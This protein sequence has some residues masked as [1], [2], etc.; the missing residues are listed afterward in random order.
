[1]NLLSGES[2]N[3]FFGGE[4]PPAV[5]RL[6]DQ[7]HGAPARET[8]ALLWTAQATAPDCLAVYYLLYKFH[9]GR[10]EFELAERAACSG[11]AVAARQAGLAED[12]RDVPA[13]S[14]DFSRPGPA[15]FW[16]FTLK[17]L[18][19]IKLRQGEVALAN[20][21]IGKIEALHPNGGLGD[22]VVAAL[23]AGLGPR[24]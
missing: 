5:S 3:S 1:M 14:V 20:A 11:L 8:E 16:L 15:R 17:A 24:R 13:G 9:A 23:L 19:F 7:I 10:R 6:L 12:W 2:S 18:A 21:L 4:V 22:D